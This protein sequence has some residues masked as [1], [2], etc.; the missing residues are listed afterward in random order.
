MFLTSRRENL[1]F[2]RHDLSRGIAGLRMVYEKRNEHSEHLQSPRSNR[3]LAI[4]T[5]R[6]R[7]PEGERA[8][9]HI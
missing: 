2:K 4:A 1:C 7:K 6:S 8:V 3:H 5:T 9:S